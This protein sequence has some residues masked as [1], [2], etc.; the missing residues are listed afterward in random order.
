MTNFLCYFYFWESLD[1]SRISVILVELVVVPICR[2]VDELKL[3]ENDLAIS[4]GRLLGELSGS[5]V[6]N[7]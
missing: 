6:I 2:D 1:D 4:A 7:S 3:N 5:F